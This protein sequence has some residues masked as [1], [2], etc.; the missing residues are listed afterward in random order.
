MVTT[1]NSPRQVIDQI[2]KDINEAIRQPEFET[3]FRG[4]GLQASGGSPDE[5]GALMRDT[6]ALWAPT[7]KRLGI[8]ID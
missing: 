7:I 4:V 1:A 3:F 6:A 8:E 5:L 2:N